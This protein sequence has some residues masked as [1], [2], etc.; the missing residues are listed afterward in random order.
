MRPV[1]AALLLLAA[2]L[3]ARGLG[4]LP[5]RKERRRRTLA[6]VTGLVTIGGALA[7]PMEEAARALFSAHMVQHLLLMVVAAPLVV[8]GLAGRTLFMGVPA[9]LRHRLAALGRR[10]RLIRLLGSPPAVWGLQAL[11]LWSWHLP[12]LYELGLAN[13]LLHAVEHGSFLGTAL[14]FWWLVVEAPGRLGHLERALLVFATAL[15]TGL[16]GAIILFA[17]TVLY[18]VHAPGTWGLTPLEDQQLA[19]AIMWI[20]MW[21]VYLATIGVLL[22]RALHRLEAEPADG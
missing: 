9:M 16:L 11:A 17:S 8:Y 6:F 15:Q 2:I 12:G 18:P 21:V 4:R 14:L 1:T 3:Y 20:P 5:G 13:E 7:F 19:G 10:L 22:V